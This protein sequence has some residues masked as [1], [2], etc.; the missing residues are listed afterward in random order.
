MKAVVEYKSQGCLHNQR[1]PV[2]SPLQTLRQVEGSVDVTLEDGPKLTFAASAR[3]ALS[4]INKTRGKPDA[5]PFA[6]IYSSRPAILQRLEPVAQDRKFAVAPQRVNPRARP[7]NY[8]VHSLNSLCDDFI[9][10]RAR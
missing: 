3:F 5:Q 7:S 1:L 4:R 6:S 10:L 8:R 9:Y 2:S